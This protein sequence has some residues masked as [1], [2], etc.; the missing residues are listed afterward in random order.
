MKPETAFTLAAVA[1]AAFLVLVPRK[2]G[3][4]GQGIVG[5]LRNVFAP[6]VGQGDSAAVWTTA[7]DLQRADSL[8]AAEQLGIW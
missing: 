5:G 1:A 6:A 8:A 2:A 4:A 7:R 3:A